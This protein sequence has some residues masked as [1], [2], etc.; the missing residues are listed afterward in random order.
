MTYKYCGECKECLP[1]DEFTTCKRESCWK[2]FT[3]DSL[4]G[5]YCI[6]CGLKNKKFIQIDKDYFCSLKCHRLH[7]KDLAQKEIDKTRKCNHCNKDPCYKFKIVGGQGV[8]CDYIAKGIDI[9]PKKLVVD[10]I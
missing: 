9:F 2:C 10:N 6:D 5:R 1:E 4:H 7:E 3:H 8:F